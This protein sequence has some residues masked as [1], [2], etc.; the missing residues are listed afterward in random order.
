MSV[1]DEQWI[2][3]RRLGH[4]SL[5]KI[6]QLSKL[7][8]VRGLP[9]LKYSS[10]A[11]CE[12]CQKGKFTKKPFKAKNVVS[13]TRPLELL[14]IDL[15]GPVKTESIGGK[16]YGLVIVDDYSRW[17]WVKFLRHKDETHTMFTNF[18]TQV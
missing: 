12:A 14:H 10:E 5:R 8:L 18:I 11:L 1:N 16:K 3:H 4:A 9:R 17:T 13:T 7:N 15:F 2:W 6:S